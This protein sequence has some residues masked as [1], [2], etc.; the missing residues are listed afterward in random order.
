[1]TTRCTPPQVPAALRGFIPPGQELRTNSQFKGNGRQ[2]SCAR[3]GV[4]RPEHTGGW[5]L[6]MGRKQWHCAAHMAPRAI[7]SVAQ[8]TNGEAPAVTSSQ[9]LISHPSQT[10]KQ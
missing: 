2:R 7:E 3:C 8:A 10:G 4:H 5:R 1:V 6:F 9:G